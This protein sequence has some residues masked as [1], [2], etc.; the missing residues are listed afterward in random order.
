[1]FHVFIASRKGGALKNFLPPLLGGSKIVLRRG[2]VFWRVSLWESPP[3]SP[4]PC[5]RM[6]GGEWR[7][8]NRRAATQYTDRTVTLVERLDQ[9]EIRANEK[10]V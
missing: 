4:S 1:M 9:E 5:P 6:G 3:P 2:T 10:K 7:W 8:R